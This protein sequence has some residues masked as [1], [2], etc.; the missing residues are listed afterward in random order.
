MPAR[1]TSRRAPCPRLP[2]SLR[3]IVR[4][5]GCVSSAASRRRHR[6]SARVVAVVS[7]APSTAMRPARLRTRPRGGRRRHRASLRSAARCRRRTV[8]RSQLGE[9]AERRL[10]RDEVRA[11]AWRRGRGHLGG[12]VALETRAG[13]R[14]GERRGEFPASTRKRVLTSRTSP[15]TPA[16]RAT[17][18]LLY[19][20]IEQRQPLQR[21]HGRVRAAERFGQRL[22]PRGPATRCAGE[23]RAQVESGIGPSRPASFGRAPPVSTGE[24]AETAV[25]PITPLIESDGGA[26]RQVES[27][28]IAAAP[29]GGSGMPAAA[30]PRAR[31]PCRRRTPSAVWG[32]G[33]KRSGSRWRSAPCRGSRSVKANCQASAP[34]S[35]QSGA[36]PASAVYGSR[37]S[38]SPR[39]RAERLTR[40]R[41]A[42]ESC[43]LEAPGGAPAGVLDHHLLERNA[44]NLEPRKA[45]PPMRRRVRRRKRRRPSCRARPSSARAGSRHRDLPAPAPG[46]RRAT[47]A[48]GPARGAAADRA[49]RARRSPAGWRCECRGRPGGRGGATGSAARGRSRPPRARARAKGPSRPRLAPPLG[50]DA[51]PDERDRGKGEDHERSERAEDLG[52]EAEGQVA[53]S[54]GGGGAI[55]RM[56]PGRSAGAKEF[57]PACAPSDARPPAVRDATLRRRRWMRQAANSAELC[58]TAT[59]R[60]P[61]RGPRAQ[62]L[63]TARKSMI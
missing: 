39:A 19:V 20:G 13:N 10:A 26:R 5:R 37:P 45:S 36:A 28:D 22:Y 43:E 33:V 2:R 46:S 52:G 62:G 16:Q 34:P 50:V 29:T 9:T 41:F 21:E 27:P 63:C 55:Q 15:G 3:A 47:G 14:R 1:G 32:A 58:C 18:N 54:G 49:N 42:G 56:P 8:R 23:K 57:R 25:A 12:D 11:Q 31:P 38:T 30:R 6:R 61:W 4:P 59:H 48:G 35:L 17:L 51:D 7:C 40:E 24:V 53:R 44:M 60:N